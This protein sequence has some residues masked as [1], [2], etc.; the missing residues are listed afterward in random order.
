[1]SDV[2]V[3]INKPITPVSKDVSLTTLG[4]AHSAAAR[5]PAVDIDYDGNAGSEIKW[6]ETR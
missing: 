1:M 2:S 3:V 6:D 4:A 5:A